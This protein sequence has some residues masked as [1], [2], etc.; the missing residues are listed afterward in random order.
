MN[1]L[2]GASPFHS[3]FSPKKKKGDSHAA[4][5]R[6]RRDLISENMSRFWQIGE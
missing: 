3:P 6:E 4:L 5:M 2:A 1:G